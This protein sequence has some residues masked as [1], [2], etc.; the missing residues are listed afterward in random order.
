MIDKVSC[1]IKMAFKGYNYKMWFNPRKSD[2][3]APNPGFKGG[4]SSGSSLEWHSNFNTRIDKVSCVIKMAF[5][6][7][8]Y[9][10]WFNPR[11]SDTFAPNPGFKGGSSSS[12]SLE[13]P[14]CEAVARLP[15]IELKPS[16]NGLFFGLW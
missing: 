15:S 3:F 16:A 11:K 4:S 2:T 7:Y 13:Y 8:N 10:T 12:S 1:V 9:K 14:A 5:K 6:G